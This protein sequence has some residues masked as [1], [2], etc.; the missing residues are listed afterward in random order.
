M[1]GW[2]GRVSQSLHFYINGRG[3]LLAVSN[4]EDWLS[5][6]RR[7]T[8]QSQSLYDVMAVCTEIQGVFSLHARA[9]KK[10]IWSRSP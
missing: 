7:E 9:L 3:G 6:L 5:F 8:K 4:V 2:T 1:F 10:V